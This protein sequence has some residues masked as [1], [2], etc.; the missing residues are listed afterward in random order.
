MKK[1]LLVCFSFALVFNV[2]AQDRVVSGKVTSTEDGSALPGVSVVL[3]GTANGTVT[4]SEGN[5]KLTVSGSDGTLLFSFIGLKGTEVVIGERT[6]VDVSLGLDVT[7]LSEIVVT[8]TGVATDRKKLAI[9]VESI[10]A[11]KLP[12]APTASI[13]Q[14]LIGKIAGAQIQATNGAPGS[15]IN[16]LLRGVNTINRGTEPMIMLDG[17]QMIGTKLNSLDL[18]S[19]ERVEVVQGAAAAAIFGAQGANGVIQVFSKKGKEG[20]LNIDFSSSVA[21]NEF[22]NIGNLRKAELHGFNTNSSNEVIGSSGNPIVQDP[23]TLVYSENVIFNSIDP[24]VNVNK[25]Y[26]KNL[27]FHDHIKEFFTSAATRN[28]SISISGGSK[29]SDFSISA[30]NNHQ[31]SN[32]KGDGY[33]DRSNLT[34]NLGLNLAKGLKFRTTT[35]VVYTENTV[36]IYNKQDFGVNSLV[37]GI[38]N[39]RPFVDYELKDPQGNYAYYYGDAA[40]VNQTNPNY[41]LQYNDTK[42]NKVDIVQSFNL[43]YSFPRFV[44]LDLKYG[45]NHQN[46]DIR[47]IA[48]NQS[49][50][51]NSSDQQAWVG[52]YNATDNTGENTNFNYKT[53]F[54]NF[55]ANATF[56]LDFDKDLKLNVP[57]KSITQGAFDYRRDYRT[58][59]FTYGLGIPLDPPVSGNQ[60]GS[61]KIQRDYISDFVTYG[62][63]VSQRFEYG[64]IAGISGGFRSDFSSAFGKG[65]EPFT[66]PRADAYLRISSLNFWNE[67]AIGKR[68]LEWKLRVAYGEAGIQPKPFDRY[69]TLTPRTLGTSNSLYYGPTQSN[70]SLAV[71]VSKETEFGTDI[72]LEGFNGNWFGDF[73]FSAT[74]WNRST[75]NAIW[76]VEA[77]PTTGVGKIKDNA[78]TISS[79]GLQASLSTKVL[80]ADNFTWSTTINWSQQSSQI[81][82]VKGGAEV[83]VTSNAGSTNYVLKAGD[84]IGQLYGFKSLGSVDQVNPAT[85]NPYLSPTEQAN[86]V[87]A[88]NGYVVNKTTKAPYFTPGQYSFGDPFPKFNTSWINDISFKGYLTVG[89]QFDWVNG[90]HLY[91]QT[92][93]WMYRDGIHS[94][95]NTPI[96]ID[97]QTGNWTAFY[98]GVYAERVRNGTKDYFYEDASFVRLRNV[99]VG[100]DFAKLLK[101]PTFKR[102]QLVLTG[103]NL[104]TWTN[105]TG[106]DPE[107][108]SGTTNSAWDRGTDHNTLPNF[109]TYQA[110]L[111]IGF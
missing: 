92:K 21:T 28:T 12:I 47:Y 100:L 16:I 75:D 82:A 104:V 23:N 54:Q 57:I 5:Y 87:V 6:V 74:Y 49:G 3:K 8:G 51:A 46:R 59:Y 71:E 30:S 106:M 50:N 37:Y 64:E 7:Q 60:A 10:T 70:P 81:D 89:F 78:F 45:I 84:K 25:P 107:I 14:A 52:W 32:F 58:E 13:D 9:A 41:T 63:L 83:V 42:D 62:Y 55:L 17:V 66:F 91:N 102:L 34:A 76:E 105:Y 29:L 109:K 27:K 110:T 33:N 97:G 86:Y 73:N 77:A 22:L 48:S 68:I 4:D 19:V 93:E 26:D 108:S 103:R 38:F 31:E 36:D 15:D 96:T 99:S 35:Q 69:P 56:K 95:Y 85:G 40:G 61:F 44:D 111:N 39:A 65:S 11:E 79:K 67:S 72:T 98:R 101:L 20:K 53:T 1:I 18:N 2:W 43:S 90:N 24:T 80:A 94:D 88:S